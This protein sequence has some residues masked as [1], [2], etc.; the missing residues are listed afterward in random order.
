MRRVVLVGDGT[1]T[2]G[3][4]DPAKLAA[5]AKSIDRIDA[6]QVGDT[7]HRR[8]TRHHRALVGRARSS[9][10]AMS[11]ARSPSSTPRRSATRPI[12]VSTATEIC[13]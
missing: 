9:I 11:L 1:P 6:I 8:A 7:S 10:A 13:P 5:L 12:A 3:E 4:S 2:L